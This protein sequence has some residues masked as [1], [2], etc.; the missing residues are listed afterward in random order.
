MGFNPN[1]NIVKL[2]L[3]GIEMEE[4]GKPAE[5]NGIFLQAWEETSHDFEKFIAN[6]INSRY[7]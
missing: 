7:N 4:K 6:F 1:N 2:C 5:A 3:R